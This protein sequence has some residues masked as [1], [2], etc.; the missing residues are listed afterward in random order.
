[1]FDNSTIDV[2][3]AA[4]GGAALIGG[5]YQG[6]NTGLRNAQRTYVGDGATIH[7]DALNTGD[8]GTAIVWAD[9]VTRF[10]GSIY[11]RGGTR[12][13]GGFA[14]VSGKQ[15]L[16][17]AGTADLASPGGRAGSLLLD[18]ENI[19]IEN[20]GDTT[21]PGD[22]D[23]DPGTHTVAFAD[24]PDDLSIDADA[25]TGVL[26]PLG[27]GSSGTDVILQALMDISV[28]ESIIVSSGSQS[29]L[30]LE[31][32]EDLNVNQT[33]NLGSGAILLIAGTAGCEPCGP[34]T[35][36]NLTIDG[37]LET[38][39]AVDLVAADDVTIRDLIGN[40]LT[41]SSLTVRAGNNV[42]VD[43][44]FVSDGSLVTTSGNV[45]LTAADG[46][47]TSDPNTPVVLP[48]GTVTG[49]IIIES[50]VDTGGGAFTA[51]G[52]SFTNSAEDNDTIVTGG[53][54]VTLRTDR[55]ANGTGVDLGRIDTRDVANPDGGLI[56]T[57]NGAVTQ[58]S[59][60]DRYLTVGDTNITAPGSAVTLEHQSNDFTG[61]VTVDASGAGDGVG[62]GDISLWDDNSLTL[63][64]LNAD[65]SAGASEDTPGGDAG[66]ITVRVDGNLTA[67]GALNA[68]GGA[69]GSASDPD[70]PPA[71][72]DDGAALITAGPGDSTLTLLSGAEAN[73]GTVTMNGAAWNADDGQDTFNIQNGVTFD[74]ATVTFNGG[75]GGDTFTLGNSVAFN[76]ATVTVDGD[77]G[78]DA[79]SVGDDITGSGSVTFNGNDGSNTL[80]STGT[81]ATWM[82][83]AVDNVNI[84]TG[85]LTL[86][87]TGIQALNGGDGDD[88]FQLTAGVTYGGDSS[89][90]GGRD[91]V[92]G[93]DQNTEWTV[94][95]A[96]SG[97]VDVGLTNDFTGIEVLQGHNSNDTFYLA[98][99]GEF[100]GELIGGGGDD[101]VTAGARTTEWLLTGSGEG[102][103]TGL[104]ETGSFSGIET[105]QGHDDFDDTFILP[106]LATFTGVE[107]AG[108]TA[109]DGSDTDTIVGDDRNTNWTVTGAGSGL[110]EGAGLDATFS[111]IEHL[112]GNTA[113]DI[114]D[115]QVASS[116]L[117]D[118]GDGG[119]DEVDVRLL[120]QT[121][122]EEGDIASTFTSDTDVRVN[123]IE[124]LLAD[125]ATDNTLRGAD[126]DRTWTI[127]DNDA[128]L[129]GGMN[130]DGFTTLVGGGADDVFEFEDET[131][132][133]E[134]DLLGG[135]SQ[136]GGNGDE[137]DFSAL[138]GIAVNIND[139]D[140]IA[141]VGITDFD[142]IASDNIDST[143]NGAPGTAWILNSDNAGSVDFEGDSAADLEFRGFNI[144][145]AG[146]S[147]DTLTLTVLAD[148]GAAPGIEINGG[149]SL[150]LDGGDA[151]L[152]ETYTSGA[153]ADAG[154][155]A[156]S[157]G[158]E[159]YTVDFDN[160][161]G[162]DLSIM[163]E[164]TAGTLRVEG[165]AGSDTLRL[166]PDRFS[167]TN[168]TAAYHA[169]AYANKGGFEFI[170]GAG[171]DTVFSS[172][173][174]FGDGTVRLDAET[175]DQAP[176]TS[177]RINAGALIL[178]A[179][180]SAGQ[181]NVLLTDIDRLHLRQ[182]GTVRLQETGNL[183][184]S[185][186][187]SNGALTLTSAGG[188]ISAPNAMTVRGGLTVEVA[189]DLRLNHPDNE[190]DGPFDLQAGG[191]MV[192]NNAGASRFDRLQAATL[193]AD[194]GG[195]IT[196]DGVFTVTGTTDLTAGAGPDQR[197][198]PATRL[199]D[200][201]QSPR[202]R[203]GLQDRPDH[204]PQRDPPDR[205]GL[206]RREV[207]RG[208]RGADS[209]GDARP[210]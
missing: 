26:D 208:R 57:A 129:T 20:N 55:P 37:A 186:V 130:F 22:S 185:E 159:T 24:T 163:D 46:S 116:I 127:T 154:R 158:A 34:A 205:Y 14:E 170:G 109:G 166:A 53:G 23:T 39:G 175:V 68:R 131:V 202:V 36:R 19:T 201:N 58:S 143:L 108:G 178:E 52:A 134:G 164:A 156:F 88:T 171:A 67:G 152:T 85:G 48:S 54:N 77:D 100:T 137:V 140:S 32:G 176:A 72:G 102:R 76:G 133:F 25:I 38:S 50:S 79:F 115:V 43:D 177:G 105:L 124:T 80:A 18:P 142:R 41:P 94:N 103:A 16:D 179:V 62:G 104:S 192:F 65:G 197:L 92:I 90:G 168:S 78:D 99:S 180:T 83:T 155:L 132:N 138:A 157:D 117:L 165:G 82:I 60:S 118:G 110:I 12:G 204:L 119:G 66:D 86:T 15:A 209:L 172:G 81:G 13:D 28:D 2:S 139:T 184:L 84:N 33:L 35:S 70:N 107:L 51:D 95:G 206:R 97:G 188:S 47:L 27:D 210:W 191:V 101:T 89:G 149:A 1:L 207:H 93:T 59:D 3:G 150:T 21:L 9:E 128:G 74:A 194:V 182:A 114:F 10:Y 29:G 135:G 198:G 153:D 120:G 96:S 122:V 183:E 73:A 64:A 71:D 167:L 160:V 111:D 136:P 174:A 113:T 91:T 144:L 173:A 189:N 40:T 200:L 61:T 196:A 63:G 181:G 106:D 45:T 44:V 190:L 6:N 11:A 49:D 31:A 17:F 162:A 5:G 69:A 126:T 8:G 187:D 169:L 121:I 195:A 145:N 75:D 125:P 151:D 147:T 42:I 123:R 199:S 203:P 161:G 112:L 148:P 7:A 146:D 30:T 98:E 56:I 141:G 4:G 193:T 87:A